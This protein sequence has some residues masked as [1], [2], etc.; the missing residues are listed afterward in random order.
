MKR[1]LLAGNGFD[2]QFNNEFCQ[3]KIISKFVNNG[4]V[5]LNIFF[6]YLNR[7][8]ISVYN[9][10]KQYETI[11]D[12]A[13]KKALVW[14]SS[15]DSIEN[16]FSNVQT[17]I[18]EETK[19]I[20]LAVIDS[21][22]QKEALF[23]FEQWCKM[24]NSNIKELDDKKLFKLSIWDLKEENIENFF[25]SVGNSVK[26]YKKIIDCLKSA[27]FDYLYSLSKTSKIEGTNLA[28]KD[29]KFDIFGFSVENDSKTV[30][31]ILLRLK[32][33]SG[34]ASIYMHYYWYTESDRELF[35]KLAESLNQDKNFKKVN[36]LIHESC[37]FYGLLE[38]NNK[39][40]KNVSNGAKK[41]ENK[42]KKTNK[43]DRE[44]RYARKARSK[45]KGNIK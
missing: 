35:N 23:L 33:V 43:N 30:R 41:N 45:S 2:I 10:L 14:S 9:D 7:V 36:Y 17:A 15:K 6:R 28:N 1:I 32:N 21:E 12:I 34:Y 27:F 37:E 16:I 20:Y 5:S 4:K 19:K 3:E 44:N 13:F 8:N 40:V 24:V 22:Y 18:K 39:N 42:Y 29:V 11:L 26:I 38:Y 25:A 31:E